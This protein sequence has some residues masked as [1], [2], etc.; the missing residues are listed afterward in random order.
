MLLELITF[1]LL[2][3]EAIGLEIENPF[4]YDYNDIPLNK[5]YQRLRDD[6]EELIND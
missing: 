3:I 1:A 5:I 2:G 6:I 4:G